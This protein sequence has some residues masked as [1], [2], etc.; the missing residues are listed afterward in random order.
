[1]GFIAG[2]QGPKWYRG[3]AEIDLEYFQ[4]ILEGISSEGKR[5]N[6]ALDDV[7]IAE[8]HLFGL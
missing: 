3:F 5:D 4:V 8:C 7:R 1:M 6:I 2:D